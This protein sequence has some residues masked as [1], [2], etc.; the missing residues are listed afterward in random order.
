MLFAYLVLAKSSLDILS[1]NLQLFAP[2]RPPA[3]TADTRPE[4]IDKMTQTPMDESAPSRSLSVT[5]L[6]SASTGKR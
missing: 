2:H 6:S 3:D 4:G 5:Y 1:W